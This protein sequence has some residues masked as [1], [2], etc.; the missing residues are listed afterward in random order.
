MAGQ[1]DHLGHA[2]GPLGLLRMLQ[3]RPDEAADL[4]SAVLEQLPGADAYR[5]ALAWALA[6]AGRHDEAR[7]IVS[8]FARR[9][10]GAIHDNYLR[11]FSLCVLARA[12]VCLGE[13]G[14]AR[15]LYEL[16]SPHHGVLVVTQTIW[17]G[18]VSH[19]LG[20]LATALSRY[21]EADGHFASAA[22]TQERIGARGT[23]MQTRL[24]W[25][26]MLLRRGEADDVERAGRLLEAARAGAAD[27]S[28][29]ITQRQIDA[30]ESNPAH[31]PHGS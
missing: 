8:D 30:L 4:W 17:L 14:W 1:P 15:E 27:A 31:E 16:L 24:E 20:L 5:T 13:I 9:S 22:Q 7:S 23:L 6:E 18:P 12:C 29:P 28:L 11:L 21:D 25:A 19:D 26:R 10:F 3:G 2:L